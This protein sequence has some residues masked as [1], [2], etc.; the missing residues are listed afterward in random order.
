MSAAH[1]IAVLFYLVFHVPLSFTEVYFIFLLIFF[2]SCEAVQESK[3]FLERNNVSKML[4][5]FVKTSILIGFSLP[6]LCSACLPSLPLTAK[7]LIW[8]PYSFLLWPPLLYFQFC[9]FSF[10]LK[11]CLP[12]SPSPL[13]YIREFLKLCFSQQK[14]APKPSC[15][16]SSTALCCVQAE[17]LVLF[18][19]LVRSLMA[20]GIILGCSLMTSLS[21]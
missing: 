8:I 20:S 13:L 4:E 6:L 3:D 2:F 21:P 5:C 17:R 19:I 11:L 1:V 9:P 7:L 15:S 10:F 16:N 12:F 18:S 14:P